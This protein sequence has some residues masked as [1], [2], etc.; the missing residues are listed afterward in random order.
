MAKTATKTASKKT[1][2]PA[3]APVAG[4]K[5]SNPVGAN[6]V[7][8][9]PIDLNVPYVLRA[10]AK[11]MGAWFNGKAKVWVAP[12]GLS[13]GDFKAAGFVGASSDAAKAA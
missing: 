7:L 6:G 8:L 1:A 10:K 5:G 12:K 9:R 4:R 3:A 2:A 11:A 13:Y